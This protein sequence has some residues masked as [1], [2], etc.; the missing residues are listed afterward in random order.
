MA[1]K[2][3]KVTRHN[4]AAIRAFRIK[5]GLKPGPFA[6][7]ALMSY[8]TLDNIENERKEASLEALYRIA[9][10]LNV[11]VEA[12]VRDPATLVVQQQSADLVSA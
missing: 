2:K 3:S 10:A 12:I 6:T 11:P 4:G 8:S 7:K 5:D 1:E 9:N